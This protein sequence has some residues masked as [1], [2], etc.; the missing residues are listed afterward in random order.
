IELLEGLPAEFR[1]TP[2]NQSL[3]AILHKNW[4][5]LP[6]GVGREDEGERHTRAALAIAERLVRAR[7]D[8]PAFQNGLATSEHNLGAVC[9]ETARLPEAEAHYGRAVAIRT[10]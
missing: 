1:D 6:G 4:G 8:D 3:L 7:P 9:Q 2:D 5:T 10:A